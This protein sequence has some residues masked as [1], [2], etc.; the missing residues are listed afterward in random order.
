MAYHLVS[1]AAVCNSSNKF[2]NTEPNSKHLEQSPDII[3]HM[4]KSMVIL[5]TISDRIDWETLR[6]K[7]EEY[8]IYTDKNRDKRGRRHLNLHDEKELGG[9]KLV[10]KVTALGSNTNL[11]FLYRQDQ[12]DDSF[13]GIDDDLPPLVPSDLPSNYPSVVPTEMASQ[14]PSLMPS[15]KPS[16]SITNA[17][18]VKIDY[19]PCPFV[20]PA[21][22]SVCGRGLCVTN[23]EGEVTVGATS[24]TCRDLEEVALQTFS[25]EECETIQALV[26]PSC[27]CD[28]GIPITRSDQPSFLPSSFLPSICPEIPTSGC[29][30]CGEGK[31][32][33]NGEAIFTNPGNNDISCSQLETIALQGGV[34]LN[35]C[36]LFP[37]LV[38]I[39]ECRDC[40]PR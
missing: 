6:N 35:Q 15:I 21:A 31:I 13:P 7:Y 8:I 26:S 25:T 38:G 29:S 14:I 16:E 4:A 5:D 32:V 39:C 24:A 40:D 36:I 33:G 11:N 3:R 12:S 17:P 10:D 1:L 37:D 18:T 27:A 23:Q 28:I 9:T 30:I 19:D 22:C 34:P 20:P 2:S